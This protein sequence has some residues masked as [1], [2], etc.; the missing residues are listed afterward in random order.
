MGILKADKQDQERL[1]S[2]LY[3]NKT[4]KI[5]IAA[6]AANVATF[7]IQFPDPGV[8]MVT[9]YMTTSATGAS[10]SGTT[11]STGLAAT[12]GAV[13]ASITANKILQVLTD[14]TGKA[15]LTL[16]AT[17]KPQGEYMCVVSGSGLV[18][19][20]AATVTASYG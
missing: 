3:G 19:M 12:T 13:A 9:V 5:T 7:T 11:Y 15:V 20:S 18:T 17:A 8:R 6:G 10:I 4:A 14:T 2:G 1:L 16:T